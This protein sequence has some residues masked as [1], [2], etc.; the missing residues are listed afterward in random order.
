MSGLA[1]YTFL[2]VGVVRNTGKTVG[3]DVRRIKKILSSA[4]SVSWFLVESDSTDDT[5]M[6]LDQLAQKTPQFTYVSLGSLEGTHPERTDRIA[7]CR[8]RYLTEL[9][10]NEQLRA[11]DYVIVA[12]FDGVNSHITASGLE[13]CWDR[14]DWDAC[15]ANQDGPY[16]DVWA[17]RHSQWCPGDCWDEFKFLQKFRKDKVRNLEAA[18]WSRMITIPPSSDWIEVESAFGGFA[19]Y[20]AGIFVDAKYD[21]VTPDGKRVC[22]HVPFHRSIGQRGARLFINPRLINAKV[23]PHSIDAAR[24]GQPPASGHKRP[25]RR[26]G[27]SLLRRIRSIS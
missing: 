8:N 2:V 25:I 10:N 3:R 9:Q 27:K 17:L 7:Y 22:E 24:R 26:L 18:V 16:Y 21:G 13:S 4:K 1:E 14:R 20:K 15:F 23:T 6:R 12:D 11:V 5:L 19:V